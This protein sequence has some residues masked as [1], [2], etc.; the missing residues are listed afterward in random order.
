MGLGCRTLT[1]YG[2]FEVDESESEAHVG[3]ELRDTSL[4]MF[5]SEEQRKGGRA[6]KGCAS[7]DGLLRLSSNN[8]GN[9]EF[10]KSNPGK[11]S[12]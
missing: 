4:M 7:P 2:T 12:E 1:F 11:L 10:S 6:E 3:L 9:P 8:E 5:F